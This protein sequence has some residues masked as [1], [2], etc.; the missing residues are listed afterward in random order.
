MK[1][2]EEFDQYY[3]K[4]LK[5]TLAL[6]E[7]KRLG[8]ANR[9]S[10]KR[11]KRNLLLLLVVDVAVGLSV[12]N[13]LIPQAFIGIIP[14]S[15]VYAMFAPLYIFIR[16]NLSFDPINEEYKKSIIPKIISFLDPQLSFKPKDGISLREFNQSNLFETPTSFQAE[17][18]VEG[19]VDGLS[20]RLSDV[21]A[22]RRSNNRNDAGKHSSYTLLHG[23]YAIVKLDRAVPSRVMIKQT[24]VVSNALGQF[25]RQ[26]LGNAIVDAVRNHLH[27]RLVKTGNEAFDKDFEVTCAEEEVAKQLLSPM[28]LQLIL[29]LKSEVG[30]QILLSM[31][32]DQLH[33]AYNGVNLFEGDAHKSF[34]EQNI[35][36]KYFL[37]LSSVV[38]MAQALQV[39]K[40]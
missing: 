23:L 31:F 38:G 37:Y 3:E 30:L 15:F 19:Q 26:V 34:V 27:L 4:E 9:F 5:P 18:L 16:R 13:N 1:S 28:L 17:D 40:N 25:A 33:I 29:A 10:Y 36:K 20:I 24:N 11:Y 21:Q 12:S 6:L 8:I 22:S 39:S 32:D 7:A 14:G 35:S 2:K